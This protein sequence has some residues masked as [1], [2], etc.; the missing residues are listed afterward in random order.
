M[1]ATLAFGLAVLAVLAAGE[2]SAQ[3]GVARGYNPLT[4][5]V[6]T[7]AVARNPFTG[8]VGVKNTTVNPFTGRAA[9]N[10]T[11]RNPYT[12]AGYRTGAAV[13]PMTGRVGAYAYGRR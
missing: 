13:N 9:T 6:N 4:G 12:G 7:T 2:A 11:V 10:T 8:T 5:R 3:V 1:R